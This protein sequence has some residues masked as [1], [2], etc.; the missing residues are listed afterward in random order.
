M[1]ACTSSCS[2]ILQAQFHLV[3]G[4][5]RTI[6]FLNQLPRRD[7]FY[8][9][10]LLAV[11]A[12][13][14]QVLILHPPDKLQGQHNYALAE[15]LLNIHYEKHF[16]NTAGVLQEHKAAASQ[17]ITVIWPLCPLLHRLHNIPSAP[18]FTVAKQISQQN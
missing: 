10:H 13:H 6:G 2:D 18:V 12:G 11:Y 15:F 9:K 1:H 16:I 4:A 8:D 3:L 14:V 17:C 5:K 7:G